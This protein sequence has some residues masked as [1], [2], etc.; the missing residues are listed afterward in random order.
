MEESLST[1]LYSASK[2][3]SSSR[4]GWVP[5]ALCH[6]FYVQS[7]YFW[8]FILPLPTFLFK[9]APPSLPHLHTPLLFLFSRPLIA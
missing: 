3:K 5:S 4:G 6:A 2:G 8:L 1:L 7:I 9:Y